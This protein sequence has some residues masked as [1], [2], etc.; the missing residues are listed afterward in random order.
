MFKSGLAFIATHIDVAGDLPA[1][2]CNGYFLRKARQSE[3]GEI[4]TRLMEKSF[5]GFSQWPPYSYRMLVT[6]DGPRRNYTPEPIPEDQWRYWVVAFSGN[7]N[8]IYDIQKILLLLSPELEFAFNVH[9]EHPDQQGAAKGWSSIPSHIVDTY[10]MFSAAFPKAKTVNSKDICA[11]GKYYKV[12]KSL[13]DEYSF[14]GRALESFA[15]IRTIPSRS[16]LRIVGYFSVLET[17]ITHQPRSAET[18]DSITHQIAN[19]AVLLNK[20]FTR[21]INPS[22]FFP[23]SDERALWK[24]LYSYRSQV[25]HGTHVDLAKENSVLKGREQVQNYLN[26]F[27]KQLLMYALMEPAFIADLREC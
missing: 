22:D 3:I 20:R 17:L 2:I 21:A 10:A 24:K 5:K 18:L 27:L 9:F 14:I 16:D 12:W 26:E 15:S 19:K 25:A 13:P 1:E 7:G 4:N 23:Q 6:E 8:E 11:M